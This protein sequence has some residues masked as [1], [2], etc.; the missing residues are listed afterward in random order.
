MRLQYIKLKD[1]EIRFNKKINILFGDI[2]TGKTSIVTIIEFIYGKKASSR[3]DLNRLLNSIR[4]KDLDYTISWQ[5]QDDDTEYSLSVVSKTISYMDLKMTLTE[6]TDHISEKT[7][8]WFELFGVKN[9]MINF[10][11][12]RQDVS[13]LLLSRTNSLK[14]L[15]PNKSSPSHTSISFLKIIG[16][17]ALSNSQERYFKVIG[18]K[19][20]LNKAIESSRKLEINTDDNVKAI[21]A[22]DDKREQLINYVELERMN[23]RE[24]DEKIFNEINELCKN[25]IDFDLNLVRTFHDKLVD[26]YNEVIEFR[27][28]QISLNIKEI[29]EMTKSDLKLAIADFKMKTEVEN[30]LEVIDE[31]IQEFEIDVKLKNLEKVNA[32]LRTYCNN[33]NK[34][35]KLIKSFNNRLLYS[36][37]DKIG[38]IRNLEIRLESTLIDE[39]REGGSNRNI[40]F[41]SFIMYMFTN[42]I[43]PVVI[44]EKAYF[45]ENPNTLKVLILE[46]LNKI[47]D[48][49]KQVFVTLHPDDNLEN[50]L[51]ANNDFNLIPTNGNFFGLYF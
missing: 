10:F 34:Y 7:G 9:E 41:T 50:S 6:Y 12:Y 17:E 45:E 46:K 19:I 40:N 13:K 35:F 1:N 44:F 39:A 24:I 32:D 48:E 42:S 18:Q 23:K 5:F 27:K 43:F 28:D 11:S 21:L 47:L 3:G 38:H 30:R 36:S 15:T 26:S 25:N 4:K 8:Y 14:F 29:N 37:D 31:Q 2:N 51:K 22:D 49:T 16:Q 20:N 33:F